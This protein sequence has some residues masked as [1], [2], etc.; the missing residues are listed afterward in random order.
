MCLKEVSLSGL[1]RISELQSTVSFRFLI[2]G[3]CDH[4]IL[5][6]APMT[7]ADNCI[8]YGFLQESSIGTIRQPFKQLGTNLQLW[9]GR[10]SKH[11]TGMSQIH[12]HT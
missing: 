3:Q 6:V 2:L 7:S 10:L 5:T 9:V 12:E 4:L 8:V 1:K 11:K